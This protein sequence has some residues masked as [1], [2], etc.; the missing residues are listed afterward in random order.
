[1]VAAARA[2]RRD[3]RGAA[4]VEFAIVANVLLLLLMLALEAAFQMLIGAALDHGAREVSRMATLGPIGGVTSRDDLLAKVLSR[5]G[6]PLGSWGTG[7]ITAER[8]TDYAALADAGALP[9]GSLCNGSGS[10]VAT[11][12]ASGGIMRYCIH[13]DARGFTPFA[14]NLLSAGLFQHRT[15]FVVQNEPY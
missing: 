1:M 9:A 8:F 13:Y 12:G 15:F 7:S 10:A 3:R 6:L 2:L 5:T 14:R 4:A 11:T